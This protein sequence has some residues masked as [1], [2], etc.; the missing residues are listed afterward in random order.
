MNRY[1]LMG[2]IAAVFF[3]AG[4]AGAI[5]VNLAT[6]ETFS[7][8]DLTVTCGQV[9]AD[10]PLAL[11]DCQYW[12]NFNEKCLFEKTT[13]TYKNLECVEDCQHWDAF[14]VTCHYQTKCTFYQAQM[15]FVRT[16]CEKFD[17][18][19]DTCLKT[20]EMKIGR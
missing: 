19:N 3:G 12:D 2:V 13:Y 11:K 17:G 20:K 15:A 10:I 18:F 5:E 8:G 14:N 6:G 16:T 9:L 4:H 1:V 7:Q